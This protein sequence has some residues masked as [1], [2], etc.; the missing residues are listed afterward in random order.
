MIT[1]PDPEQSFVWETVLSR[2]QGELSY[3]S[4]TLTCMPAQ[5]PFSEWQ[6]RE[7][8]IKCSYTLPELMQTMLVAIVQ[9]VFCM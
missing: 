9:H 3:L 6:W 2:E 8:Q 7:S 5:T 1:I 4:I